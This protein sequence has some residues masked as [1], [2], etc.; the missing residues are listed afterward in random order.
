MGLLFYSGPE[1]KNK[2]IVMISKEA[3]AIASQCRHYAMCKIDFLGTGL[4][5]AGEAHHYVSYYPQGRM[6]IYYALAHDLI[7]VTEELV[8]IAHTCTL[9]GICDQQCHFVTELRPL[10][11]MRALKEYVDAHLKE[12]RPVVKVEG[13]EVLK[14][15]REVVGDNHAANDPAILVT[16]ADDPFPLTQMKMPRYI[17]LPGSPKEVSDI[18]KI[19]K[20]NNIAY[21]VR[22]NGSS[23]I[24]MVMS[25]GLVMDMNRLKEI[26]IDR[27]NWLAEIGPGVSAFDLQTEARK[28]GL[29]ANTA[30]PSALVCANIMCSGIFSTFSNAYGT[31]ADNYTNAEFVGHDGE[32]FNLNDKNAPNLFAFEKNGA[33][34]P[35]ICTRAFIRLH[36]TTPD[37]SGILVPFSTFAEAAAF[38]RE[39]SARRIGI[40]I[41]LLGTEYISTFISPTAELAAKAKKFFNE[42][43]GMPY[44]VLVIGD[45]YAREAIKK[46]SGPIMD[47]QL[48]RLLA[49]GLPRLVE[50][51]W[52]DLLEPLQGEEHLYKVFCKEEIYSLLEAVLTPSPQAIGDAVPGDLKEFYIRLYSRPEMTDLVWVNTSRILSSRMGR[53]K[54][55]VASLGY[56]PLDDLD[57]IMAMISQFKHIGD[58][59]DIKNDYGFMTPVD[60]GKRA[61][62]E[63][64]YYIN[65]RDPSEIRRMQKVLAE[66]A[67]MVETLRQENK[68]IQWI[69]TI[70]NQGFSRKESFLYM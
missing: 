65:H 51:E 27:S 41:A 35:G 46:M 24:G 31:G 53:F 5:P 9:C 22:G 48:F 6:D 14:R 44:G 63:Y 33:P 26:T 57:L 70:L 69:N 11:V 20:H 59:Y 10:E 17:V 37:E 34:L 49:L 61:I 56:V 13:D 28:H 1:G 66:T 68:G 43:L 15:L 2:E 40:S 64:D 47:E 23:V 25:E 55:V 3:A 21:A 62:L 30:E 7:P 38:C 18:V 52:L 32:S 29:R 16:Y 67:G 58:K 50:G 8:Q 42:T 45:T 4:C 54:H 36:P 39:L 12:N 19:C 60:L